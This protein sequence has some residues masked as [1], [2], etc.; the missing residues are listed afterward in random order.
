MIRRLGSDEK[1]PYELLLL[2]DE[3]VE[4]IDRYIFESEV[5]VY[6][7]DN[8]IAGVYALNSLSHDVLEIEN[9]AVHPLHQNKGI[10]KVMLHHAE[11]RATDRCAKTLIVGTGDV[12]YRQLYFYQKSGFEMYDLRPGFYLNNYPEPIFENGLQLR[13]MV[14]LKK[15]IHELQEKKEFSNLRI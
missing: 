9:I 3:F 2:A 7:I 4:V 15:E 8:Q 5:Y 11:T 13:H 1:I 6:E 10:G 12:M 14:M